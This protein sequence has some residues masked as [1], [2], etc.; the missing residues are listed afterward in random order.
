MKLRSHQLWKTIPSITP[1][2]YFW[3]IRGPDIMPCSRRRLMRK[4]SA[5]VSKRC[6][7]SK[8]PKRHEMATPRSCR[9]DMG[10]ESHRCGRRGRSFRTRCMGAGIAARHC[11]DGG[12]HGAAKQDVAVTSAHGREEFHVRDCDDSPHYR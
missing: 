4:V 12:V 3:W 2:R 6:E 11:H 9:P 7:S 1:R 5:G 8:D 10:A